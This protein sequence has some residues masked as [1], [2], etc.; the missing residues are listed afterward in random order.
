MNASSTLTIKE[1]GHEVGKGEAKKAQKFQKGKVRNRKQTV[2]E[3]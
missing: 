1:K 3:T 2:K